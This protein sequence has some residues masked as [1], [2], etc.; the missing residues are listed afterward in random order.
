M[1]QPRTI[2]QHYTANFAGRPVSLSLSLSFG[3]QICQNKPQCFANTQPVPTHTNRSDCVSVCVC[4]CDFSAWFSIDKSFWHSRRTN[5]HSSSSS[6]FHNGHTYSLTA[7]SLPGGWLL[8]MCVCT[9]VCFPLSLTLHCLAFCLFW[10]PFAEKSTRKRNDDINVCCLRFSHTHTHTNTF[11]HTLNFNV[12]NCEKCAAKEIARTSSW[13]QLWAEGEEEE[14]VTVTARESNQKER[15][16][17]DERWQGEQDRR[18][19]THSEREGR[20]RERRGERVAE[21]CLFCFMCAV[22]FRCRA[23][24]SK[25]D[26]NQQRKLCHKQQQ[27]Q[28]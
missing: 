26:E 5:L 13:R 24:C 15:E 23:N 10:L 25:I 22:L 8:R 9:C 21:L 3:Y 18:A 14:R 27:Q 17:C 7:T 19:Q 2:W 6:K 1:R 20:G 12:D 4:V 11:T 16:W 28:Q